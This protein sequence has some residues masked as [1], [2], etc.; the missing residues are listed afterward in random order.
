MNRSSNK[1]LWD[2]SKD[3]QVCSP[4][5]VDG[6]PTELNPN[7]TLH[8]SY[9][10]H[11]KAELLSPVGVKRKIKYRQHEDFVSSISKR[12]MGPRKKT[13]NHVETAAGLSNMPANT[14]ETTQKPQSDQLEGG[15][16]VKEK[17]DLI[18]E[19]QTFN[20]FPNLEC[21]S[22][23]LGDNLIEKE[24]IQEFLEESKAANIY[25]KLL[26]QKNCKFYTNIDQTA[27]FHKLHDKIAPL[28]M[29]R[30]RLKDENT[31]TRGFKTTPKK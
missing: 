1:K 17:L 2:P 24:P 21:G 6:E 7:P 29:R 25:D 23:S 27:L 14:T 26:S 4:H 31:V 10:S 20:Y 8:M 3:S 11:K 9:D 13:A 18:P 16:K 22:S 15:N 30:Y 5:F 28:V 19:E 12:K